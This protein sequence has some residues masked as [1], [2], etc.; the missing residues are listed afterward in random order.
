MPSFRDRFLTPKVAQAIVSPSAIVAT[1][2]GAA[3]GILVASGPMMPVAAVG[4]GA[5]ALA[6][7]VGLAVPR[8]PRGERI[9]PF[10]LQEPWRRLTQAAI[11]SRLQ[12]QRTAG[13]IPPG[14]IRDRLQAIGGQIDHMVDDVWATAK[15]GH[16]LDAAYAQLNPAEDAAALDALRRR[17]VADPTAQATEASLLAQLDAAQRIATTRTQAEDRLRLLNA[18]LEE[19]VARCIEL[20]VGGFRPDEFAAL[21]GSIGSIT[22]ELE[23]LRQAVE[24]TQAIGRGGAT[25]G[26]SATG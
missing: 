18:R 13:Q 22:D 3:L 26:G 25:A 21:E 10:Q 5:L 23:A 8:A 9:D 24:V 7:R 6:V 15:G 17:G 2:A 16:R 12:F 11:A 20:S 19:A 1:G 14:P 4:L